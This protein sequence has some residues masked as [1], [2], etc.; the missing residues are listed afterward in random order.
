MTEQ[1]QTQQQTVA[2]STWCTEI[3]EEGYILIRAPEDR[4]QALQQA[5]KELGLEEEGIADDCIGLKRQPALDGYPNPVLVP[6]SALVAIGMGVECIKCGR[7]CH[8]NHKRTPGFTW[9]GP[10][11]PCCSA[12]CAAKVAGAPGASVPVTDTAP[13]GSNHT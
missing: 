1:S 12:E 13:T 2:Y 5:K 7:A 4:A 9:A 6:D 11:R 10:E 8:P 3:P